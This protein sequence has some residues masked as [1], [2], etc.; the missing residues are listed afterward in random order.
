MNEGF[1]MYSKGSAISSFV[2]RCLCTAGLAMFALGAQAEYVWVERDDAS[3]ATVH[4]GRLDGERITAGDAAKAVVRSGGDQVKV[5]ADGERLRLTGLDAA[6]DVRIRTHVEQSEGVLMY[7]QARFGRSDTSP[8][9][10]F[11][12]V[13]TEPGGNTFQLM[14]MGNP[15]KAGQ[16]R[17]VTSEGWTRVL[18]PSE[19]G[20]ITLTTP[21]PGLYV[22]YMSA[23]TSG[24]AEVDGKRYKDVRHTASLSFMVD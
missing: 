14:W 16:V 13:P 8:E 18:D 23:R 21:F 4:A 2:T 22:L 5:S 6:Q 11:E 17:V 12:L 1:A 3:S 10:D 7:Y 24:W 19:D 9:L 20:T 15:M